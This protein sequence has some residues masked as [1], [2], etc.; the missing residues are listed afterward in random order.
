MVKKKYKSRQKNKMP[1]ILIAIISFVGF[2]VFF[3]A[4]RGLSDN[5]PITD[6]PEQQNQRQNKEFVQELLPVAKQIQEQYGL[7]PSI[8]IGQAIL[9]S[10]WGTSELSAKYN[11]LFGI[12][13]FSPED[14]FVKLKTKEFK[15]GKWIEVSANFKVYKNWE[16]CMLDHAALF[17]H[18]VDWDPYLYNGVLL[19][20][21]YQTAASAL[22]VAGYATDPTYA[23]K[24]VDVIESHKLYQYD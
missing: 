3:V 18:G 5:T 15:D 2:F 22:Q 1:M 17:A 24:I 4:I 13:S 7:L 10:D 12:K 9:E 20:D 14:D 6:N 23:K 19:A 8:S 21:N 11:N 16:E